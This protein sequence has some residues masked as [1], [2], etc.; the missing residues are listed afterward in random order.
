MKNR[1]YIDNLF[2]TEG[3][4]KVL[5]ELDEFQPIAKEIQVFKNGYDIIMKNIV[6]IKMKNEDAEYLKCQG[7]F[8]NF[9]GVN[10]TVIDYGDIEV[11]QGKV[12]YS[13]GSN[14]IIDLYKV[15]EGI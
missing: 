11:N 13:D 2:T 14:K 10:I 4:E 8:S 6:S 9:N 15:K 5:R 12:I 3:F 7:Y 1:Q